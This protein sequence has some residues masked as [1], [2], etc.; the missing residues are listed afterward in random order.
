MLDQ[1]H[2]LRALPHHTNGFVMAKMP[3]IDD[4]VPLTH[5]AQHLAMHLAHQRAGGIDHVQTAPF[6][7]VL[8][9]WGDAVR[10]EHHRRM[11]PGGFVGNLI[12]LLDEHRALRGELL[13]HMAVVYDL[14]THI[15]RRQTMTV[16][17]VAGTG[18]FHNGLHRKYRPIHASA[19]PTRIGQ[20]NAFAHI[21]CLP[22]HSTIPPKHSRPAAT[23]HAHALLNSQRSSGAESEFY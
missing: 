9:Q 23:A 16:V 8:D 14:P 11:R 15:H 6:R 19:E 4:L 7:L 5:E 1:M 21:A 17:A 12:K 3:D 18:G 13:D 10:G 2:M 22:L 20:N